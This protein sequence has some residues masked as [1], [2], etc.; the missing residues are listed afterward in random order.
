[1]EMKERYQHTVYNC[2]YYIVF[3]PRVDKRKAYVNLRKNIG[4]ILRRLCEY[5]GV[6]I[7]R[8]NA[9][10]NYIFMVVKIP[11]KLSVA[12]FMGYLKGKS[13]IMIFERYANID[14]DNSQR[15]FWMRG[16][17][18]S[19]TEITDDEIEEYVRRQEMSN[20]M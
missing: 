3:L 1:M 11:P 12:Q 7:V 6:E 5:K 17:L 15:T 2:L 10:L 19:T 20:F 16:Y 9:S 8:A 4:S 14:I 18:V 13:A